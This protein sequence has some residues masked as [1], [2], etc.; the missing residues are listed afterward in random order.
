M[1][2]AVTPRSDVDSA[3][4][5]PEGRPFLTAEWRHFLMLSYKIH[6][7]ALKPFVPSGTELD[8]WNHRC[9]LS[10]V[11][12]LFLEA[13]LFGLR[14]PLHSRFEE[15]NLR[16]YVRHKSDGQWRRGIVFLRELAA[17]RAVAWT[18]RWCYGE[19]FLRVPMSHRIDHADRREA[20]RSI[21]Y[22]WQFKGRNNRLAGE[23]VDPPH[24]PDPGSLDEFVVD[25]YWAYTARRR[26]AVEYLVPH[27]PWRISS[28]I[29]AEF[30]CD[31]ERQYGPRFAPFLCGQPASAFWADG[32]PVRVFPG[33]RF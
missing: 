10:V 16:F 24:A 2:A 7:Q 9:Y 8:R 21:E 13:R 25:H 23:F 5:C 14:T 33:R 26:G 4:P 28:A 32:S 18:A 20:P 30:D 12:F 19:R 3:L 29:H 31:V 6:P 22:A 27:A 15:V 1:A 17:K 11:G